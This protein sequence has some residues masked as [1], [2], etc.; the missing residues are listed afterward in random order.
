MGAI[1]NARTADR[2][3]RRGEHDESSLDSGMRMSGKQDRRDDISGLPPGTEPGP[4]RRP[5]SL[6]A[7]ALLACLAACSGGGDSPTPTG[8]TPPTGTTPVVYTPIGAS[9]AAGVGGSVPCLPLA[10]S[11]RD[12][13]SYVGL[14][15]RRLGETRTVS[16][17]NLALPG[18]VLSP[19]IETL[20]NELGRGIPGN[21]INQLAPFVPPSTTLVTIFAGGNDV[22][23][24][25][26]AI[27]AGRG[28]SDPAA[29]LT[30]H[31]QGYARD[32]GRLIDAIRARAPG[33][34]IVVLNAPNFG[35]LPYIAGRPL[36]ERRIVQEVAVRLTREAINPLSGRLPVVDLM[37]DARSYNPGIYSADGFHPND[38][39]YAYLAEM[40]LSAITAGSAPA[41]AA[42]C[43]AMTLVG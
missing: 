28:G 30:Q 36:N 43:G 18:A 24:I 19:D 8:P 11:C 34:F 37:C 1:N 14:I 41:P 39:G 33:A 16:L 6:A 17:L 3:S 25:A 31:V 29:F 10:T 20:G 40:L 2:A 38:A 9:D 21:Y 23:T 15:Q 32:Y 5:A 22:N 27:G 13:T 35:A 26:S 7:A 12:S 42:S 4:A